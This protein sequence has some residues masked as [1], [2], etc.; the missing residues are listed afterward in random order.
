MGYRLVRMAGYP[1][2]PNARE[3]ALRTTALTRS[4]SAS[5]RGQPLLLGFLWGGLF[6]FARI[7]VA[8]IPPLALVLYRVSIATVVLHI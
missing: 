8:E 6:F 1:Q 5:D 7:A 4:M 3:D 2:I